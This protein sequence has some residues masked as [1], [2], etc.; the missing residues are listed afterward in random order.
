MRER[1]KKRLGA[2]SARFTDAE[3]DEFLST[4]TT[5]YELGGGAHNALILDIALALAYLRMATDTARYFK[6]TE[7]SESVDKTDISRQYMRLYESVWS[8][9]AGRL[10]NAAA[11]TTFIIRKNEETPC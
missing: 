7:G 10:P 5:D 3:L 8:T 4:A 2:D 6:Y 1:L 11:P 9:V